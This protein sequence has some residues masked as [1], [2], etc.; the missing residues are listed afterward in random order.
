MR[1]NR[2]AG[3]RQRETGQS[4]KRLDRADGYVS[5]TRAGAFAHTLAKGN[6]LDMEKRNGFAGLLA[7]IVGAEPFDVTEEPAAN[8]VRHLYRMKR[9]SSDSRAASICE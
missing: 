6:V 7:L 5:V 4:Q 8:G 3:R 2:L 9:S 1:R